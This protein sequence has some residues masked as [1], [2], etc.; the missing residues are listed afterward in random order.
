MGL[1]GGRVR[2]HQ[3][4]IVGY[5]QAVP[6]AGFEWFVHE[7]GQQLLRPRT[8]GVTSWRRFS[9]LQATP[10]LF[11]E[12]VDLDA[13]DGASA[14]D[15]LD[16]A[17]KYGWLGLPDWLSPPEAGPMVDWGMWEHHE[18]WHEESRVLKLVLWVLDALR[19][20]DSSPTRTRARQRL[21]RWFSVEGHGRIQEA[22]FHHGDTI[23]ADAFLAYRAEPPIT[24]LIP[25][26]ISRREM[27]EFRW[28]ADLRQMGA[29]APLDLAQDFVR[30]MVSHRLSQNTSLVL[31]PSVELASRFFLVQE[32]TNLLGVI[33]LQASFTMQGQ[34]TQSR[35]SW[36]REWFDIPSNKRGMAQNALFCSPAHRAADFRRKKKLAQR[37]LREGK[38]PSHV[39]KTLGSDVKSVRRWAKDSRHRS[40]R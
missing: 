40:S 33:W 34:L 20:S 22:V 5:E 24:D 35:C 31:V 3:A 26:R 6:Y 10:T 18:V 32:P 19:E 25:R 13:E 38:T 14:S 23:Q 16:F 12:F 17:N 36:C 29:G 27:A 7:S 28:S 37:M 30:R 4:P 39:A 21:S 2:Q 9:P 8:G 1:A 11:R 15:V